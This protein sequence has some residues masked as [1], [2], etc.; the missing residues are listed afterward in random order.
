VKLDGNKLTLDQIKALVDMGSNPTSAQLSNMGVIASGE[1]GYYSIF[2][3]QK[4]DE[5]RRTREMKFDVG[6]IAGFAMRK[7]ARENKNNED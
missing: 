1:E 4:F 7:S 5:A 6:D 3:M 2:D